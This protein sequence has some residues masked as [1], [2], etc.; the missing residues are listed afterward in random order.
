[1]SEEPVIATEEAAPA[2]APADT[3]AAEAPQEQA[4][5]AEP[6]TTTTETTGTTE[7][8][9][10]T[11]TTGTT[12]A[13]ATTVNADSGEKV[14]GTV[15]RWNMERGFGFI[16][17]SDESEDIFVHFSAIEGMTG[18]KQLPEGE[19][20]YFEVVTGADGRKKA[21]NVTIKGI[22]TPEDNVRKA[23]VSRWRADKNFG[24]LKPEDEGPDVFVHGSAIH[25][26]GGF[27]GLEQGASVEFTSTEEGGR[28][29]KAVKVTAP[30]G[31]PISIPPPQQAFGMRGAANPMYGALAAAAAARGF[32]GPIRGGYG[33]GMGAGVGA[34]GGG[35]GG[36]GA[37]GRPGPYSR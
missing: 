34:Y 11:E 17:P 22:W 14:T 28:G 12:E 25:T 36:Y 13:T 9:A 33:Y 3:T 30:G 18:N 26:S 16:T 19:T 37:G 35:Y 2:A 27:V 8:T 29:V 21:V 1:M 15:K 31:Q 6:A 24:F 32:G 10:T 4:A 5:A 7:T 23:I 20:V